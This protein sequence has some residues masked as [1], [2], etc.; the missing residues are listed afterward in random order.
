V[1]NSE[2][3]NIAD[4]GARFGAIPQRAWSRKYPSDEQNGCRLA[5]NCLL[6]WNENRKILLDTGVG[7]K[8]LDKLSYYRFCDTK[9][10]RY[11]IRSQIFEPEQIK[12][13]LLPLLHFDHCGGCTY[14]NETG[15][16]QVSFPNATTG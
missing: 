10:L 13:V 16:L 14:R 8:D 12:G 3:I 15:N 6:V 5:M 11:W 2:F 7:N 4:G 9:D 1:L